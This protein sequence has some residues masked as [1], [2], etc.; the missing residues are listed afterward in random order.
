[1]PANVN[2][3]GPL[4]L[5]LSD[6]GFRRLYATRLA[7]QACDGVFQASLAGFVLFSPER[8]TTAGSLAAAAAVL[9]LPYSVVGPVAGV[10]IDRVSRARILVVANLT[11]AV[12]VA[13]VALVILAGNAGALFYVVALLAFAVNRFVLSALSAAL[14]GVTPADQLVTANSLST[15]SG[16]LSTVVGAG[17]GAGIAAIVSA[18]GAGHDP[19]QAAAAFAGAGGYVLAAG[20][21]R[22]LPTE[23]LGPHDRPTDRAREAVAQAFRDLAAGAAYLWR[24]RVA[25]DALAAQTSHRFCYG[26][27]TV[28]AVLL[29]RNLFEHRGGIF[30][31]GATG[32]GEI[33]VAT[34][35]GSVTAAV[36]TPWITHRIGTQPWMAVVFAGGG[37]GL[38]A[39]GLPFAPA[40]LVAAALLLGFVGQASKVCTDTIV[41]RNVEDAFRGRA[42][43]FYDQLFNIAYV[44]AAAAGAALLPTS[45]RSVAILCVTGAGY[46]L[47]AVGLMVATARLPVAVRR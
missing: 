28:T 2:G 9:L 18:A 23:R 31:G 26:L 8:A 15:T 22:L 17:I 24:R 1:L 10:V 42:F 7:G 3:V 4:R 13:L 32:L 36:V 33:V 30:H 44:A 16:T 41:Q 40:G 14:P 34:G 38:V 19:G 5:L 27:W 20:V 46:L 25:R 11:R 35:I 47:T 39:L 45:G 21:A 12:I 37:V 29:E 43:A 6:S